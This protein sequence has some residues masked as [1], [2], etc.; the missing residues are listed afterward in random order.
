MACWPKIFNSYKLASFFTFILLIDHA[1]YDFDVTNMCL[2]INYWVIPSKSRKIKKN[3]ISLFLNKWRSDT[4]HCHRNRY[5]RDRHTIIKVIVLII[6]RL[7]LGKFIFNEATS[8]IFFASRIPRSVKIFVC[9]AE[10]LSLS[11]L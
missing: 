1:E 9:S 2:T 4:W 11:Q 8:F 3:E 7:K 6:K 5:L 10:S